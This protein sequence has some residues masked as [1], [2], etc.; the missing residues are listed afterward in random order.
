MKRKMRKGLKDSLSGA[1]LSLFASVL[2]GCAAVERPPLAAQPSGTAFSRDAVQ[3]YVDGGQCAGLVSILYNKGVCEVGCIG[4]ADRE[5]RRPMTLDSMYMIASQSK[6]ICGIAAAILIEE[7]KLDLED[8]VSK[9][10]PDYTN[11]TVW[12]T[13]SDSAGKRIQ[14]PVPV[15]H[16]M[17]V[18]NLLTHTA[19]FSFSSP[20]SRK[21][22]W[23][24][25]PIRVNAAIGATYPLAYEPGTR[26]A[27]SNFGIDVAAAVVEVVSGARI[28][29]FLRGRIFQPLG[30]K[31]TTFWP[32]E[33]QL[34]RAMMP[35]YVGR[36]NPAYRIE[37]RP[38]MPKPYNGPDVFP[39]LGAGLWSSPRDLVK[40]YK[41]LLN[42]GVGDNGAR[43]LKAET[44]MELLEKDQIPATAVVK[45]NYRYSLGLQVDGASG[46]YGHGGAWTTDCRINPREDKLKFLAQQIDYVWPKEEPKPF[47]D[48]LHRAED[49][50]LKRKPGEDAS[51]AA[52]VGRRSE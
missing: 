4:W 42:R 13:V 2:S 16:T 43:I 51:G 12:A 1:F 37:G 50:F 9:Y 14:T 19:G 35:Y 30:M 23:T 17:T 49:E 10:L 31:D 24:R 21:V 6:G 11:L 27:Y 22:G 18:R 38:T 46:W 15:K 33:E 40:F 26:F 5:R 8:P 52:F 25:V 39:S 7:G 32:T 28:E 44:V 29:E 48:A 36:D 3:P 41:M 20:V 47:L 45:E 34:G